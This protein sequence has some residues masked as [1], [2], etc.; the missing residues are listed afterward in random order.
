MIGSPLLAPVLPALVPLTPLLLLCWLVSGYRTM[1]ALRIAPWAAAPALVVSLLPGYEL[2]GSFS[3]LL[4][5]SSLGLDQTGRPFLFLFAVLWLAAGFY[6]RGY[7]A[8]DPERRRFQIFFLLT[9]SGNLGLPLCQGVLDY[10]VFFALMSFS[11]YGLVVHDGSPFARRAGRLYMVLV[12]IGEVALFVGLAYAAQAAESTRLD[13]IAT[14]LATA[15]QRNLIIALLL[16]GF[17]IKAGLVPLHIWLPLAHPAAPIPAS[18]VL[19]G[20]MIKAGLLGLLRLLPLGEMVLPGWSQLLLCAGVLMAFFGILVGVT[21]T[22]PKTVLAYSSISQM[23]FPIIG[24]GIGLGEPASWPLLAP[25]IA[26]YAVHH[27]LAKGALFLGVGMVQ[28]TADR[29]IRHLA[30]P[31]GLILPALALAGAPLTSGALAK[32]QLKRFT[33]GALSPWPDLLPVVLPLAAVGTTLLL[34][35]FFYLLGKAKQPDHPPTT[36]MWLGWLGVIAG[37]LFC[38]VA[39]FPGRPPSLSGVAPAWG[40]LWPVITGLVVA[41]TCWLRAAGKPLPQQPLVPEGDCAIIAERLT[42]AIEQLGRRLWQAI[43]A[44]LSGL[45]DFLHGQSRTIADAIEPAGTERTLR[46]LPIAGLLF[47]IFLLLLLFL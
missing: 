27:G 24:I 7:L 6:S 18:A 32:D 29:T 11:A 45:R 15:P 26:L 16:V 5:G 19:S 44:R 39:G 17:G 35:R 1:A 22:R 14:A 33:S 20:A 2:S 42:V 30:V 4:L 13:Q 46:R 36:T 41:L 12:L 47:M 43:D 9:M 10:Y 31:A 21:Q 37:S 34:A 23:G 38:A 40:Q 25:V 8:D 28:L 3:W